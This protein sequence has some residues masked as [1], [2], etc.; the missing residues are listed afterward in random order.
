VTLEDKSL[1]KEAKD[2]EPDKVLETFDPTPSK[3]M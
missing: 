3:A 2:T 1:L